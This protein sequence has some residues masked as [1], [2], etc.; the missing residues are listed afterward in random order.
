MWQIRNLKEEHEQELQDV[1][2]SKNKQ[3]EK[4]KLEL[5]AKIA[6]L[7]QELLKFEADIDAISR[8]LQ[9]RSSMLIKISEEKSRAEAEIERL[10]GNIDSCEREINSLKYEIHVLSKELEIRNEE[11]NMSMRSAEAANKQHMEGVKKIAKLEAECQRLRGLVRKKL[12]GPAAL[13]QMKLEVE[14][15]GRDFGNT[16]FKRSPLRPSTLQL[17]TVADFSFDSAQKSHMEHECF[18]ERIL[19]M[20]EETKMLKEALAIRNSELLASRNLCA[21]TS[22]KLHTLEA[23]LAISNRQS[24]SKAIAQI[25]T[26]VYSSQIASNP[27][28]MT[29]LSADG[30]D[31]DISCS[32]SSAIALIPGV[33]QFKKENITE[34]LN[35]TENTM[36]VDL[37]DDFLEMEKLA[38]S[39]NDPTANGAI[40]ISG[41][42][43]D[44]ISETFN[45]DA[46]R[47]ISSNELH[48]EKQHDLSPPTNHI[49][50][51][52]KLSVTKLRARLL[53]VLQSTSGDA[54]MRKILEDIKRA[55]QDASETLSQHSVNGVSD[56]T[57][58]GQAYPGDDSLNKE[59]KNHTS[60]GDKA[61]FETVRQELAT[62]LSHIHDFVRFLGK[63][64]RAVDISSDRKGLNYKIDEFLVTYDKVFCSKVCLDD[65]VFDL[66]AVLAE[67]NELR[68]NVL[69][70]EGN[71][72]E[73]S[74]PDCIDKVALPE[75]K[76][77]P[78]D[79]L[80]ASYRNNS[81]RISNPSNQEAPEDGNIVSEYQPKQS[82]EFSS[83]ELKELKLE[84]EKMTM[85]LSLCTE[86]LEMTISQLHETKLLLAEAKS[87]L[88]YAERSNSLAET[89]LKCMTE[90]YRSLERRAN[91]L[92]TEVNLLLVKIEALENELLDEKRCHHD[93]FA[94]CKELEEQLQRNE[95][96]SVCSSAA[97]NDLKSK[98]EKELAEKLAECQRTIF[99][100]GKQL[101]AFRPQTDVIG[102]PYNEKSRNGESFDNEDPTTS[103]IN[104]Q[105]LYQT[106]I[107]SGG[108]ASG[109]GT[110]TIAESPGESFSIPCS[111]SVT[112]ENPLRSPMNSKPRPTRSSSSSL[113]STP[114]P[115]KHSRGFSRFFSSKG[116]NDH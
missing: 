36:H 62:A 21:K 84:K 51:A 24:P 116:K 103:G 29:S 9:E 20:E 89:Q 106:K 67:A 85:D 8:S 64:A 57:C 34:K 87:Q 37:M 63:E 41:C 72:V 113:S 19:A 90:S 110:R 74:S 17:S 13:A 92:E 96:C 2:L 50:D 111:P 98:Q 70:Y 94:R 30:N 27:P 5:E 107:D 73:I 78:N 49:L 86:N 46:S 43:N 65:F 55:V 80:G 28:S 75:N 18:T 54:D 88:V 38:S 91:E 77:T 1:V 93:A 25:P 104:L 95:N 109:I 99:L 105:D 47:E 61:T 52:D 16:R 53:M 79:P 42:T 66:S 32:E 81:A 71:E 6:N 48:Y 101:K 15:S 58:N 44:K 23:Q 108:A 3:C 12:P 60:P 14:S 10:K 114:T 39:S 102:S 56:G 22:S 112:Q 7:D 11:K 69:G 115:E 31:D 97:A 40:I 83:G 82:N 4:I 35:K 59:E 68:F 33:S 26:E 45:G 100:L 76:V